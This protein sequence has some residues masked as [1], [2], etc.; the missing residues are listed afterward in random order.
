MSKKV[1]TPVVATPV[2]PVD[3]MVAIKEAQAKLKA[4]REKRKSESEEE[5]ALR[6]SWKTTSLQGCSP[7]WETLQLPQSGLLSL[8]SSPS[9]RSGLRFKPQSKRLYP[10]RSRKRSPRPQREQGEVD[11]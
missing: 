8:H 10:P 3:P 7:A 9:R 4:I 1:T 6:R 5:K 2:A 11:R